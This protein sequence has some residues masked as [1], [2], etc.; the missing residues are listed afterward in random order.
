MKQ[1][2]VAALPRVDDLIAIGGEPAHYLARVRRVGVGDRLAVTS[3]DG[4]RGEVE[5]VTVTPQQIDAR[6]VWIRK[7]SHVDALQLVHCLLKQR[8]TDGVVRQAT[9][10]G[11]THV[12][13]AVSERSVSRPTASELAKKRRRWEQIAIEAS[14]QSGRPGVPQLQ[15][16]ESLSGALVPTGEARKLVFHQDAAQELGSVRLAPLGAA[17]VL[18]GP[19]GGLSAAEVAAATSAGWEA[20]RLPGSVL[21]AETAAIVALALVKYGRTQ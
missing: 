11:A 7:P 14:Q 19:E 16:F 4:T 20:V 6:I 12:A 21:R 8:K 2:V 17:Q 18:V 13:I 9:E 3:S 5:L 10:L 15:V 1:L